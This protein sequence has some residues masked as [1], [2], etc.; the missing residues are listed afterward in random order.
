MV[1]PR[2]RKSWEGLLERV[3]GIEPARSAWEADRLPL[4]HTR[5]SGG[6]TATECPRR[7]SAGLDAR[8]AD[9]ISADLPAGAERWPSGRRRTPGKCVYGKT[10]SR[11]RIPPAPPLRNKAGYAWQVPEPV[12]H[13][14]RDQHVRLSHR[15]D[16]A[17]ASGPSPV[18]LWSIKRSTDEA[19]HCQCGWSSSRRIKR[20]GSAGRGCKAFPRPLAGWRTHPV[21]A[22]LHHMDDPADHPPVIDPAPPHAPCSATAASAPQTAPRSTRACNRGARITSEGS[23]EI[24]R[25][26][27][28][29]RPP[30]PCGVHLRS[31]IGASGNS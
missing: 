21:I 20:N 16:H 24:L 30:E 11:V 5:L 12:I 1:R 18:A 3:A 14:R 27:P 25:T 10:V 28:Q 23:W 29:P 2:C 6:R 22:R 8:T 7:S 26:G 17:V 19:R 9:A 13:M 31:G 4:H 15:N